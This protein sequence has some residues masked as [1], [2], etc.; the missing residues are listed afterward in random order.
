MVYG[1]GERRAVEDEWRSRG[2]ECGAGGVAMEELGIG[3]LFG[4]FSGGVE[5]IGGVEVARWQAEKRG[6]VA[7]GGGSRKES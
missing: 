6:G 5:R 2:E 4:D 3:D 1:G 7:L